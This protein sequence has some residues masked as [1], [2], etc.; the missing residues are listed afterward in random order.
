MILTGAWLGISYIRSFQKVEF[1]FVGNAGVKAS[2]Y[3]AVS[4]DH[5]TDAAAAANKKNLVREVSNN[6]TIKLK[7]GDYVIATSGNKD[8]AS[9]DVTLSLNNTK[10]TITIDPEYT[11]AKLGTLLKQQRAALQQAIVTALP[12]AIH[13]YTVGEGHL[14]QHGDWYGTTLQPKL[15]AEQLRVNYVDIYRLVAHKEKSGWKIIT[16]PPELSLSRIKYPTIPRDIL[17]DVNKLSP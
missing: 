2:I 11:V 7:K 8:Y 14:Y 15:S 6:Q 4:S 3:R 1:R 16:L 5:E 13:N 9:Q 17:V 12:A 10:Q